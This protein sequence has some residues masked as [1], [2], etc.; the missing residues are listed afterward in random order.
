VFLPR[1]IASQPSTF[2]NVAANW[3][4][5]VFIAFS[6]FFLSPFVVRTLGDTAYGT[7]SLLT[8]MVG[9]LG[10]L[11]LGIR[12]AVMRYVANHHGAKR[13]DQS[14]AITRAGLALFAVL[15]GV[16]VLAAIVAALIVPA[17]NV[18][19]EFVRAARVVIVLGGITVATTLISAPFGAIVSAMQRFDL[20]SFVDI[21]LEIA[22]IV[23][24]VTALR[25]GASLVALAVI[26]LSIA[27]ARG[28]ANW[29]LA[30]V[31]Y[32]ESRTAAAPWDRSHVRTVFVFGAVSSAIFV[33]RQVIFSA[34][35]MVIGAFL[36][37]AAITLFVIGANLTDYARAV[38][39]GFA[40]TVTPRVSRLDAQAD[41]GALRALIL[42]SGAIASLV[43]LPIAITLLMRGGTFIGLWMGEKYA[44][45]SGQVLAVLS[46]ALAFWAGHQVMA[47]ALMG[48]NRHRP[49]AIAYAAEAATNLALS[50]ALVQ[51]TGIMGVAWATTV[52][53]LIVTLVVSPVLLRHIVQIPIAVT[54]AR[55]WARPLIAMLPF[56]AASWLMDSRTAPGSVLVF[57]LQ[58]GALLPL[59]IAGSW[60][61]A[62]D[63]ATRS[64]IASRASGAWRA[65][66]LAVDVRRGRN[67]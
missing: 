46:I 64:A 50:V 57:F 34:D 63:P 15:G 31:L 67:P 30:G 33:S 2:R 42:D 27:G 66:A 6:S 39:N 35:A 32:P 53:S 59:A 43:V 41:H 54:F 61:V 22:R 65:L 4:A 3:I 23:A 55:V 52:P 21:F 62:L 60:F 36:P 51:R 44:A 8:S 37:V 1:L 7:W 16:A 17:F 38:V 5:F 26:Q 58:V 28:L 14:A 45:P 9:Y 24:I 20:S 25:M 13:H 10:L 12:S 56:A 19:P 49:L 29:Y 48:L 47:V 11:D 18:P 40:A